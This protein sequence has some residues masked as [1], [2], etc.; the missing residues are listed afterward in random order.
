MLGAS[1]KIRLKL[2]G[3]STDPQYSETA[4]GSVLYREN[5][6]TISGYEPVSS[7][8]VTAPANGWSGEDVGLHVELDARH[9]S[10]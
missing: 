2:V 7:S 10:T 9:L 5:S 6:S 8:V 1:D 4:A 3:S